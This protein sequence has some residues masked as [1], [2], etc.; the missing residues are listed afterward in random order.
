MNMELI[1]G[2]GK[3]GCFRRSVVYVELDKVFSR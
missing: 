3:S 1:F 2:S